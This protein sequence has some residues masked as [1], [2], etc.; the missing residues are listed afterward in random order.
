MK[1]QNYAQAILARD[2]GMP[3]HDVLTTFNLTQGKFWRAV[4]SLDEIIEDMTGNNRVQLTQLAE[5]SERRSNLFHMTPEYLSW[6]YQQARDLGR[7]FGRGT[8]SH[9]DNIDFLVFHA[10]TT[11]YVGLTLGDRKKV[12][13]AL[14]EM[15]PDLTHEMVDLKLGYVLYTLFEG[16][17]RKAL[18]IIDK[19]YQERTGHKSLFDISEQEHMHPWEHFK[20]PLNYWLNELNVETAVYHVLVEQCPDFASVQRTVVLNALKQLKRDHSN[21]SVYLKQD[22]GLDSAMQ[23]HFGSINSPFKMLQAFDSVYKRRTGDVSLFDLEAET[24]LHIWEDFDAPKDYWN[25]S[26]NVT[27]A[28]YHTLCDKV[29]RWSKNRQEVLTRLNGISITSRN[30]FELGLRSLMLNGFNDRTTNCVDV[31]RVYD[32]QYTLLTGQPSLFDTSQSSY[33]TIQAHNR[34]SVVLNP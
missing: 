25:S 12:L 4:D 7:S 13:T 20:V 24:H 32:A 33:L 22:L 17:P 19:H 9:P 26:E 5:S 28:V 6:Q 27:T 23:Y 1:Q 29:T 18:V 11:K 34:V 14:R 3:Y 31:L 15:P 16:F 21:F 2:N 8:Y 10:F 30:F